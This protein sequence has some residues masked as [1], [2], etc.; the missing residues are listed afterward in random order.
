MIKTVGTQDGTNSIL[1]EK[2]ESIVELFEMY[3]NLVDVTN[4]LSPENIVLMQVPTIRNLRKNEHINERIKLFNDKINAFAGHENYKV[5]NMYDLTKA[6]PSYDSLYYDN[7][8]FHCKP[9]VPF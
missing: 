5:A 4:A 1:K 9:G 2:H 7:L 3:T 8:H 6:I